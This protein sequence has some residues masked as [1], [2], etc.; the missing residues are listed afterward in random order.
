MNEWT[1]S[2]PNYS[3]AK[4]IYG[5]GEKESKV[6]S[7]GSSTALGNDV[8]AISGYMDIMLTGDSYLSKKRNSKGEAL[9]LG[10]KYFMKSALSCKDID[11]GKSKPRMIYIN[12]VP[13]GSIAGSAP[14]KMKGLIPGI[15]QNIF[16]IN[17]STML[18]DMGNSNEPP[19]V[20]VGLEVIDSTN[21]LNKKSE[22]YVA[23]SDL[24]NLRNNYKTTMSNGKE[25]FSL[26]ELKRWVKKS[27]LDPKQIERFSNVNELHGG[28]FK[29][30][31]L[32]LYST[33]IIILFSYILYRCMKK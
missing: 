20:K 23:V 29:T 25:P 19:C 31:G 14:T 17:P 12:N 11:T 15:I 1:Y 9:P 5:T 4:S 21:E 28:T 3:Y 8:A 16:S 27:K 2:A 13:T 30:T 10:G 22:E 33:G 24:I 6:S 26:D 32:M 18:E 7:E